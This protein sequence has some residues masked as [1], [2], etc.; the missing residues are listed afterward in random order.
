MKLKKICK[1]CRE[2]DSGF[3][4]VEENKTDPLHTCDDWDANNEYFTQIKQTAPWYIKEPYNNNR[5]DYSRFIELLEMDERG[6]PIDVN[7]YDAIDKI[8]DMN[9]I[10]LAEALGVSLG[11][12]NRARSNGTVEN[13]AIEFSEKLNIP[14]QYFK[15]CTTHNFK[16]LKKCRTMFD[17]TNKVSSIGSKG[18][19]WKA[20]K[21]IPHIAEILRCSN[22]FAAQF[23]SIYKLDWST[24]TNMEKLTKNEYTLVNYILKTFSKKNYKMIKILYWVDNLGYARLKLRYF[25]KDQLYK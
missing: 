8:Y 25:D 12:I 24:S 5:I 4:V 17:K 11:V 22:E 20:E 18:L 15:Q 21:L 9:P 7:I 23:S 14:I 1:T 16:Q 13:R 19:P 10:E 3:C 6:E 2:N